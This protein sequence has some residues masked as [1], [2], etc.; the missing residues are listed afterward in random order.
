G[1][2]RLASNGYLS[3][4]FDRFGVMS[5]LESQLKPRGKVVLISPDQEEARNLQVLLGAEGYGV[6]LFSDKAQALMACS[7][8]P[9]D[10]IIIGTF[11]RESCEDLLAGVKL[12]S[13]R[14]DIPCFLVLDAV[15]G[16]NSK[17]VTAEARTRKSGAEGLYPLILE[18]EKT[19]AH[20]WGEDRSGR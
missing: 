5:L 13:E 4:P 10:F 19:Y 15:P 11:P 16:R 14:A 7:D 17:Q 20:K 3:K 12:V 6:K 8:S 9:P 2:L 18:V 1:E